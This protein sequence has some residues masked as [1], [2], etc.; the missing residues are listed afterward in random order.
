MNANWQPQMPVIKDW[1]DLAAKKLADANIPTNKLD[2]ELILA[3][4]LGK[5]RTFLHAH[6]ELKIEETTLKTADNMLLSRLKRMPIAYLTGIK[7]F[8]GRQFKVNKDTLIPRP[9]SE[10]IIESLKEITAIDG[11]HKNL[12]LI[13]V[14]TGSGCLGI[15]AK[16]ELPFLDVTLIDI[17]SKALNIA[18]ENANSL[19][20]YVSTVQSDLLAAYN[21]TVDIIIANLPYVDKSWDRSPETE[22]EPGL[23]LFADDYGMELIKKLVIQSTD[24][25][26]KQGYLIIEADPDQHNN[27]ITFAKQNHFEVLSIKDYIVSFR[28]LN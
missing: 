17:S 21:D 20:T 11:P 7:E 19:S 14:G 13:D 22:Y 12:K 4:C 28:Y 2:A 25:L 5:N 9:E 6:P 16:L 3:Y 27:I 26:Q 18:K 8:Y 23:A 15:T 1:L 10:M 24:K